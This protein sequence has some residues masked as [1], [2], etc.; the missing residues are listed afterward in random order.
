MY[1]YLNPDTKNLKCKKTLVIF[2][3]IYGKI[4]TKSSKARLN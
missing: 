1:I 4:Q 3:I 2:G